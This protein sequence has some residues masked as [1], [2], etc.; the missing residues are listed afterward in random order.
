DSRMAASEPVWRVVLTVARQLER[1]PGRAAGL[2]FSRPSTEAL[3]GLPHHDPGPCS[4]VTSQGGWG[5]CFQVWS[6]LSR[7]WLPKFNLVALRIHD[8]TE[9]P[10]LGVVRLLQDVAPFVPKR[11]KESIQVF[12]AIVDHEGRLAWREVLTVGG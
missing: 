10:V 8:P 6:S 11:L 1:S 12:D 9:L 3:L 2:G 4:T 7:G 5:L